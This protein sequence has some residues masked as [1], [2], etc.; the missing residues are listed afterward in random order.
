[1][2]SWVGRIDKFDDLSILPGDL[3]EAHAALSVSLVHDR[4]CGVYFILF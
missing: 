1:M 2:A 3:Q 4:A